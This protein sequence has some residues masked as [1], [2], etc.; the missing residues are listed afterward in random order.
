MRKSSPRRR[1]D[2]RTHP[3]LQPTAPLAGDDLIDLRVR[4]HLAFDSLSKWQGTRTDLR[5]LMTSA[6]VAR[7]L[8]ALGYGAD[9]LA[10]LDRAARVLAAAKDLPPGPIGICGS[11]LPA[12]AWLLQFHD[13]QRAVVSTRDYLRALIRVRS[14]PS[15]FGLWRV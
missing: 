1:V 2:R 3:M 4:E 10:E 13:A 5:Q 7:E 8:A 15:R 12:V 6:A 9:E 14:D 11:L